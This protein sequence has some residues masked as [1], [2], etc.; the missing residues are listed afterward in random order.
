LGVQSEFDASVF[1]GVTDVELFDG[2]VT[3][4]AEEVVLERFNGSLVR[5]RAD[6]VFLC[7]ASW[8]P[9]V[10]LASGVVHRVAGVALAAFRSA[11]TYNEG[12]R[13]FL[14]LHTKQK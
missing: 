14:K 1:V 3:V 9:V 13:L 7:W 12:L 11:L 2:K 4:M 10:T 8:V 6:L 5:I